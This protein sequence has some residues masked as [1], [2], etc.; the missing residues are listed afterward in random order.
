M[1]DL[2]SLTWDRTHIPCSGRQ[3]LHHWT[4]QGSPQNMLFPYKIVEDF[5]ASDRMSFLFDARC[6]T[7]VLSD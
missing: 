4:G 7:T 5:K 2:R 6:K 3:S 1:W